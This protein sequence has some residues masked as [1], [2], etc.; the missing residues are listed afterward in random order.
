MCHNFFA[1]ETVSTLSDYSKGY[2]YSAAVKPASAK[3]YMKADKTVKE[4]SALNKKYIQNINEK[5]NVNNANLI[6]ISTPSTKNWNMAKHNG[7]AQ[8]ANELQLEYMCSAH[9]LS[10]LPRT[11][12]TGASVFN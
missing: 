2:H 3:G 7:I 5:C 4:I 10:L 12:Y 8:L 9:S 6:L 1:R 11:T